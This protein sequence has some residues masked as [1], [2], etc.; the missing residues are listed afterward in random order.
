[1][2]VFNQMI[3][4][5]LKIIEMG[6]PKVLE[7]LANTN[8]T[9]ATTDLGKIKWC[10]NAGQWGSDFGCC[11]MQDKSACPDG[12][13]AGTLKGYPRCRGGNISDDG[14]TNTNGQ[15]LLQSISD[16]ELST[17]NDLETKF[18][19]K[20]SQYKNAFQD[21][22]TDLTNKQNAPSASYKNKVIKN[23]QGVHIWVNNMGY[24]FQHI[25]CYV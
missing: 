6:S 17:L 21:Y 11:V 14:E 2:Q 16:N 10:K 23:D 15:A 22:L 24:Y 12:R 20:L 18:D 9:C 19:N 25:F 8:D 1:M 3:D 13:S 4:P 7:G 5:Q